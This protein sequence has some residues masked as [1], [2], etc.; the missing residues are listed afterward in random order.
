MSGCFLG[1]IASWLP[2]NCLVLHPPDHNPYCLICARKDK[3]LISYARQKEGKKCCRDKQEAG[4]EKGRPVIADAGKQS[5][6]HGAKRR[7]GPANVVTKSGA[8]R[9][10]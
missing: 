8:S 10:E 5:K 4:V 1:F 3:D 6:E 7:H 2:D 9:A